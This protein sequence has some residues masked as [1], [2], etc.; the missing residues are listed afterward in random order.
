MLFTADQE[1]LSVVYLSNECQLNVGC[2]NVCVPSLDSVLVSSLLTQ[3]LLSPAA[4]ALACTA[5]SAASTA[6][7]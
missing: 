5:T 6:A 1:F 4:V 3:E 2:F 7:C